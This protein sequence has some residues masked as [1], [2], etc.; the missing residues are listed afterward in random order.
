MNPGKIP[1]RSR[2]RTRYR[3]WWSTP[4]PWVVLGALWL[5]LLLEIWNQAT[6]GWRAYHAPMPG[7]PERE[8]RT[9][10]TNE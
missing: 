3:T 1:W 5:A 10:K 4:A 2:W 8:V 7:L 9:T 6:T